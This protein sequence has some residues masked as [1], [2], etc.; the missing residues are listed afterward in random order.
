MILKVI[1]IFHPTIPIDLLSSPNLNCSCC[2]FSIKI[3]TDLSYTHK[4]LARDLKVKLISEFRFTFLLTP[5]LLYNT[6]CALFPNADFSLFFLFLFFCSFHTFN[7]VCQPLL[8]PFALV[9]I[10]ALLFIL[11]CI[12]F[13]KRVSE[14]TTYFSHSRF[15]YSKR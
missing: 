14:F 6:L 7:K 1:L 10:F 8:L 3:K 11:F 9:L 12:Y 2:H 15:L 5:Y 13:V 4:F